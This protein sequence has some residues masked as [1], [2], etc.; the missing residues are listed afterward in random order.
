MPADSKET[1]LQSFRVDQSARRLSSFPL[2]IED[3]IAHALSLGF[4]PI[5]AFAS[6]KVCRRM[7]A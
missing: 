6:V 1:A 7:Y 2:R 4:E 3:I 5:R